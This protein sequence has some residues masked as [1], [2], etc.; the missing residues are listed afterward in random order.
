MN[1]EQIVRVRNHLLYVSKA[2]LADIKGN[3]DNLYQSNKELDRLYSYSGLMRNATKEQFYTQFRENINMATNMRYMSRMLKFYM[4]NLE[5][6]MHEYQD[7]TQIINHFLDGLRTV[8]TGR[9]SPALILPDVLY[10]L[11]TRVVND[12]LKRNPEFIPIFT[13]LKNY[14]QQAM[15]S[16]TNTEKMLI[17]QIS[18]LFKNRV[19]K[20]MNL[21]KLVT[22]LVPFDKDTYEEKHNTY[23]QLKL[24]EDHLSVTADAYITLHGHQLQ[25]CYQ[26]GSTYYCESLHFTSHTS[27]HNCASA[28]YF[29]A[30]LEQVVEKCQFVYNHNYIPEPKILE[31]QTLILL[32]NLPRPWQLVY[33]SQTEHPVPMASSP[34]AIIKREDLCSCGII[35]QHYF[36]HENMIR[37]SFPDNEVTLYYVHNKILLD[38]HVKGEEK[39]DHTSVKLLL[40]PPQ[41]SIKDLQVIQGKFPKVL[42]R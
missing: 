7:L 27:E 5:M 39:L 33:G 20:P 29:K 6:Q 42:V 13:T 10:Q 21:Y 35:A 25:G 40:E 34:Y 26:Q 16:F 12:I 23:T 18:I 15:T 37:C 31:T 30:P 32:S 17:V 36:L 11:I 14:Y 28:I 24:K 41:T 22:V 38:F 4:S 9:L 8:N 3:R 1:N 19:Q 2:S